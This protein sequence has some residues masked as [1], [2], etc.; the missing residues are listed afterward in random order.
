MKKCLSAF[1][2]FLML[3]PLKVHAA[4]KLSAEDCIESIRMTKFS[5][6]ER[7]LFLQFFVDYKNVLLPRT[8]PDRIKFAESFNW[9]KSIYWKQ[10]EKDGVL[11]GYEDGGLTDYDVAYAAAIFREMDSATIQ[12]LYGAAWSE[13]LLNAFLTQFHEEVLQNYHIQLHEA[14]NVGCDAKDEIL[15]LPKPFSLK[16][17]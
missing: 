8:E 15:T 6:L 14:S 13:N 3:S 12:S 4:E 5:N 9:R 10:Q 2:L 7:K 1:L 16:A 11:A 17:K